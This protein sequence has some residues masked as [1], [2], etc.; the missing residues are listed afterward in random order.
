MTEEGL[1]GDEIRQ[2]GCLCG[3]VRYRIDGPMREIIACHCKQCQR[4]SGHIVAATAC[5]R[6]QLHFETSK[7]LRWFVSSETAERGFCAR[8]GSSLFWR[9]RDSDHVSVMAGA[10]DT[11]TALRL[12]HHIFVADKADYVELTD[13]LPK[14]SG[15]GKAA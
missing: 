1:A 2:G 8:C 10:L 3:A 15:T 11:P 5:R 6:D 14:H 13:G 9:E 7:S 12:T 4:W